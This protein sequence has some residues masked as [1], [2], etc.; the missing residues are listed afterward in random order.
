LSL[1]ESSFP[2]SKTIADLGTKSLGVYMGNI[3][4]IYVTAV[5]MYRLTPW[6]LGILPIYVPILFIAGLGGPLLF[7]WIVRKT[8]L[9]PA[10]RYLFG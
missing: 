1:N 7:M 2:Y 6:V 5:I 9:R 4:A 10:Y 3:P 8:P